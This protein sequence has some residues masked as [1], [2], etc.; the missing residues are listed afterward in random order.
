M[1]DHHKYYKSRYYENG[2]QFWFNLD[3]GSTKPK[4]HEELS[5]NMI[6]SDVSQVSQLF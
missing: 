5:K 1:Q 3:D 4:F 2:R 6:F